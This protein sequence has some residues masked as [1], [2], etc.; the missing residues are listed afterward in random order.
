VFF[1]HF[2]F[3][4]RERTGLEE[5]AV[6]DPHLPDVVERGRA[7]QVLEERLIDELA[8]C[9]AGTECNFSITP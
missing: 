7:V 1:H 2:I 3:F 8:E 5:D 6:R 4:G 9:F